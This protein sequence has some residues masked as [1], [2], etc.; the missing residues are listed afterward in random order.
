MPSHTLLLLDLFPRCVRSRV[1]ARRL[2]QMRSLSR[3]VSWVDMRLASPPRNR[4]PDMVPV[5]IGTEEPRESVGRNA[6]RINEINLAA[7]T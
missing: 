3:I 6:E 4:V 5:I 2:R 1:V 7:A